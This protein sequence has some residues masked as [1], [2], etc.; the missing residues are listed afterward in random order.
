MRLQEAVV[1]LERE[2][3]RRMAVGA[4]YVHKQVDYAIEDIGTLDADQNEVYPLGNP[5]YGFSTTFFDAFGVEREFPK[6]VRDYDALELSLEKRLSNNWAGR[7]GYTLSRLYGNYSGL[8]QSD[9]NGRTSPNVGRN[10]DYPVMSFNQE[11]EFVFGRLGTDRPHQLK[12]SGLYDFDFGTTIGANAYIASGV[13]VTR[14]V[15]TVAPNNFPV[16]YLGRLSDG[17]TEMFSQTDL[18]VSHDFKLGGDKRIQ[19]SFNVINLFNQKAETNKYTTE[20]ASGQGVD[21]DER[22][23]Y[24]GFDAAALISA[25]KLDRDP[26]FLQSSAFQE[27]LSARFGVKFSF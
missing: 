6:A 16:Q 13:P 27:Q 3:G 8:S 9:E 20:L 17:R 5:G 15:A 22:Q 11:G 19:L 26:R 25:Q 12:V 14:E 21:I 4:R 10:F 18:F 24:N 23:F 2:I 1:G 7:V